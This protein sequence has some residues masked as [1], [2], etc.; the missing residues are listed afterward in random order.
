MIQSSIN[1]SSMYR[2]LV[3]AERRRRFGNRGYEARELSAL[4]QLPSLAATAGYA[5]LRG[6]DRLFRA[7]AC[8][9]RQQIAISGRCDESEHPVGFR[10]QLDQNDPAP[11]AGEEIDL[12]GLADDGACF[13]RGGD[14]HF[15]AGQPR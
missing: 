2:R 1:E 3:S 13:A 15:A 6:A 5:V 10:I 11:W 7:S 9:D 12:V 4:Q 14:Q 8:F